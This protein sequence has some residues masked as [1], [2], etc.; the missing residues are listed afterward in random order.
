[1]KR[2]TFLRTSVIGTGA[3]AFSGTLWQNA[4]LAA[5]A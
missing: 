2:R 5:P 1:M 3:V 4:A